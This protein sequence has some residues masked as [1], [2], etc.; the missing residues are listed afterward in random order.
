MSGLAVGS[1]VTHRNSPTLGVGKVFCVWDRYACIGFIDNAGSRQV[2]RLDK[3]VLD[4]VAPPVALRQFD[5][6]HVP[7]TSDCREVPALLMPSRKGSKRPAVAW[8]SE[9][10][11]E[12]FLAKYP[13]G[14]AGSSYQAAERSWKARQTA[15]WQELFSPG[16]LR[17]LVAADPAEAGACVMKVVQTKQVALL[18]RTS[19]LPMLNW[20]LR[21]GSPAPFLLAL[22]DVLDAEAP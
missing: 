21:H 11:L 19:E 13:D 18:A 12:R 14:M 15:L 1:F 16:K 8:T 2:K 7:T 5:G 6:W 3:S 20:A 17:E 4:V 9:Q 10:A 22:A